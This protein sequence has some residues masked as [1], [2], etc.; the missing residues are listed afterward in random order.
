MAHTHS[1]D[2]ISE[3]KAHA[4]RR[5]GCVVVTVSD[6]RTSVTDRGGP[7]VAACLEAGGHD[8]VRRHIVAD[9]HQAIREVLDSGLQ[10]P[11]VQALLFT[12]GTGVSPRDITPEVL[13]PRFDKQLPGFGELFR[14]LSYHEVG[15]AAML[16]RAVAGTIGDKVIFALPGSPKALESAVS[17]LIVPELGHIVGML[18]SAKR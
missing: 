14:M 18:G 2:P 8:V 3:H 12:G 16:S 6:S 7:T 9:D 10:D 1:H 13:T 5:V 17:T 11:A 4:P 15:A